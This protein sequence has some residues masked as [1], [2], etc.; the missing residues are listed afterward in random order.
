MKR[1]ISAAAMIVLGTAMV[2]PLHATAQIKVNIF[3]NEAPPAPR[4]EVVPAPRRG[5]VWAPGYWNWNGQRHDWKQGSWVRAR[6]GQEYQRSEWYK[7]N[8]GWR[9]RQG[10]WKEAKKQAK[11]DRKEA[12]HEAKFHR[13]EGH[14]GKGGG[15]CPPGQAKKGNC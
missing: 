9:L 14:H 11:R 1:L 8:D 12:K 3:V 4:Y 13:D 5:Y 10:S 2:L 15:H 6:A 7:D